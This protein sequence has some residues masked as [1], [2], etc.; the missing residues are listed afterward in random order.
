MFKSPTTYPDAVFSPQ[1]TEEQLQLLD[2]DAVAGHDSQHVHQ[3]VWQKRNQHTQRQKLSIRRQRRRPECARVR[4][5]CESAIRRL[6]TDISDK[7]WW[8]HETQTA[9]YTVSWAIYYSDQSK[10]A[11]LH[12]STQ[13]CCHVNKTYTTSN[14]KQ[15]CFAQ[16]CLM[17]SVYQWP[18]DI[19]LILI[20]IYQAIQVQPQ[21]K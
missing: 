9:F 1:H 21:R 2:C 3:E 4:V 10:S 6:F 14:L 8:G 19:N 5:L 18:R 15:S 7:I 17:R 11:A 16:H 12:P 13:S 20:L